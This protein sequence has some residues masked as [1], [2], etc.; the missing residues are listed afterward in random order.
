MM[1]QVEQGGQQLT[2]E[3]CVHPPCG[4]MLPAESGTLPHRPWTPMS[5]VNGRHRKRSAAGGWSE[6]EV[7]AE[8]VAA[9]RKRMRGGFSAEAA[10]ASWGSSCR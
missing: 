9:P 10:R 5:L 6:A 2:S 4:Q 1:L 3:S 7:C 8:E